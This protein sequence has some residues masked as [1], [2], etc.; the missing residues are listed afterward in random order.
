M[1]KNPL[2]SV[3]IPTYNEEKLIGKCVNALVHQSLPQDMYEILVVDNNSR[4]NTSRVAEAAG[5]KVLFYKEKQGAHAARQY[6]TSQA[7]ADI[8]VYTDA[9]SIPTHDWL[10]KI[11]TIMQNKKYVC[12]G[13]TILPT[14]ANIFI[15]FLFT[16]YDILSLIN[17]FFHISLIWGPN[18]AVRKSAFMKIGGFNS[19]LKTS[20]DWDF[21]MRIQ[22]E[23]GRSST[24]YTPQL[25]VRTSSRR[26]EKISSMLPFIF[27]GMFNYSSIFL[28]RKSVTYGSQSNIR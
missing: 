3:V 25:Q 11:Y 21:V 5:A 4:D 6:G 13:G 2:L 18:M 8:I 16:C 14:D 26:Q 23:F 27:V 20:D 12:I 9:D 15:R 22:K 7:K 17:Q 28:F 10:E 1:A 19:N 24:L